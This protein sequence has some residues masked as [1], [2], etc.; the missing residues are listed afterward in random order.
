[1]KEYMSKSVSD[2]KD[3]EDDIT[4]DAEVKEAMQVAAR[5]L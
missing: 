3:I 4:T 1:M 2:D 5:A